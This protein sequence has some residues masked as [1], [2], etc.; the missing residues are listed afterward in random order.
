MSILRYTDVGDVWQT[1]KAVKTLFTFE[2][3]VEYLTK[4]CRS[5]NTKVQ[6]TDMV[7]KGELF[8]FVMLFVIENVKVEWL[9]N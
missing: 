5:D 2:L 8:C 4:N 9:E 3:F 7:T 6:L 1:V